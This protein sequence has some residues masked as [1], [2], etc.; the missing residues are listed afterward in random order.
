MKMSETEKSMEEAESSEAHKKKLEV[1]KT[2]DGGEEM[3]VSEEH[4]WAKRVH[5]RRVV[6]R[7]YEVGPD[8][9]RKEV[10]DEVEVAGG[11][12]KKTAKA[13]SKAIADGGVEEEGE[14]GAVMFYGEGRPV[15]RGKR[16][17][18]VLEEKSSSSSGRRSFLFFPEENEEAPVPEKAVPEK[19]A[20]K[21]AAGKKAAK[22]VSIRFSSLPTT[23]RV[24]PLLLWLKAFQVHPQP[25]ALRVIPL[26]SSQHRQSQHTASITHSCSTTHKYS[27]T[28]SRL[29]AHVSKC[30]CVY[31]GSGILC[32]A[33][34]ADRG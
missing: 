7:T 32:S 13:K 10:K 4:K 20:G 15:V 34:P 26:L 17:E 33:I 22:K 6:K 21:K 29:I 3:S 25:H 8:G 14:D 5:K 16:G 12:G 19:A 2:A 9:S 28:H 31:K 23:P 27:A 30:V 24:I 11:A 1:R 18:I